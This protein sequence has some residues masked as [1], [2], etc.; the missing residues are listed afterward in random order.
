LCSAR[1]GRASASGAS[2]WAD[3]GAA[4]QVDETHRAPP[5]QVHP[6]FKSEFFRH[7]LP[8]DTIAALVANLA[9]GRVP[10][11]SRELDFTP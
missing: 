11:Q 1:A 6:Y 7:A 10:G 4:D 8:T 9:E 2:S 5:L 3:L